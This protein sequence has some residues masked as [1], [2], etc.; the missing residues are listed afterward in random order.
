MKT[1]MFVYLVA[2]LIENRQGRLIGR[3][4]IGQE[5]IIRDNEKV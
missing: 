5:A 4:C 2:G 3:E 1:G